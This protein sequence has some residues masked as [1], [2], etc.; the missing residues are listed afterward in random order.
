LEVR[1][2]NTAAQDMY[3]KH[4]FVVDGRRPRYYKDNHEDAVMMS[5]DGL[6][7]EP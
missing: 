1:A 5:L 4:G 3:R 7:E 6:P 2:G